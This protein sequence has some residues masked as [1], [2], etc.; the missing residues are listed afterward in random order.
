M[1]YCLFFSSWYSL[2]F[3]SNQVIKLTGCRVYGVEPQPRMITLINVTI[4]MNEYNTRANWIE[5]HPT[6]NAKSSNFVTMRDRVKIYNNIINTDTSARLKIVYD[7]GP[8]WACSSV[9]QASA[10]D[11]DNANQ[12]IIP[13]IRLEEII[14]EDVLL[15]KIDVEG[16]PNSLRL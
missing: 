8:C 6:E 11:T 2:S 4:E 13:A 15:M 16:K 14:K 1:V 9:H 7:N 5:K 3:T 12:Y 10:S